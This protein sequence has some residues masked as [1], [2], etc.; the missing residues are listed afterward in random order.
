MRLDNCAKMGL[1]YAITAYYAEIAMWRFTS[2]LLNRQ[3]KI[4]RWVAKVRL[5]QSKI[6]PEIVR[7]RI[8][9]TQSRRRHGIKSE[10]SKRYERTLLELY[11]QSQTLTEQENILLNEYEKVLGELGVHTTTGKRCL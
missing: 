3:S 2:G 1:C 8:L 6:Q 9:F 10:K 7:C 4:E 11:R 5:L